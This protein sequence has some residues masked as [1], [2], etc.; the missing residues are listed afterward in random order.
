MTNSLKQFHKNIESI[1]T[2]DG[3]YTYFESQVKAVNISEI[4]IA[5]LV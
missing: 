5:N 2:I 4:G 1:N 3:I